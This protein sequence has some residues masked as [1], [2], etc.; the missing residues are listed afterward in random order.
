VLDI[1]N[2][3]AHVHSYQ[4]RRR[5]VARPF[6]IGNFEGFKGPDTTLFPPR[7]LPSRRRSVGGFILHCRGWAQN[8]QNAATTP[9]SAPLVVKFKINLIPGRVNPERHEATTLR[10]RPPAGIGCISRPS[11][12]GGRSRE[13]TTNEIYPNSTTSTTQWQTEPAER[14][15]KQ[16]P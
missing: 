11:R 3:H 9:P 4:M 12:I 16:Y 5:F 10:K 6:I 1:R 13:P 7:A 14:F 8:G 15:Q 2:C